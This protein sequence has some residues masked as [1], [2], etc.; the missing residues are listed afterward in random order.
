M[1]MLIGRAQEPGVLFQEMEGLEARSLLSPPGFI[2]EVG[3]VRAVI[4]YHVCGVIVA[5][6]L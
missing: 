6:M 5:R 2:V 3:N 1:L 4:G